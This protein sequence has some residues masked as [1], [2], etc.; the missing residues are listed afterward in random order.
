MFD[1][2]IMLQTEVW[3][4]LLVTA[5]FATALAFF[6]QT[7]FQNFTSPTRVALIFATEPVFA[8]VTSYFWIGE[9]LTMAAIT[10]CFF[11]LFGMILA[12]LPSKKIKKTELKSD[13]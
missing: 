5:I 3:I 13:V 4:A 2:A 6:A 12:E 10:G 8:A 7:Y 1:P 9:T 11:I